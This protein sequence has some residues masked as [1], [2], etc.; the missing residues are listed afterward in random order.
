MW[1]EQS[2][3]LK[4]E[5]KSRSASLCNIQED[6]T[7]ALKEGVEEEEIQFNS[8]QAAKLQGEVLNMKQE[9]NKVRE[10]LQTG[11]DHISILQLEIEKTLKQLNDEFGITSDQPQLQHTMSK[12]R[13]PLRAFIFGGKP[14]KQKSIFSFMHPNRKFQVV[15]TGFALTN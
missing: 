1:L 4:D 7:R 9:N 3:T 6:I 2:A 8:H 12:S 15:R 10:E 5:L 11:L 13:V 14:K